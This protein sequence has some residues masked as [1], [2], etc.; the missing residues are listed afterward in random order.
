MTQQPDPVKGI[1][2]YLHHEGAKG[3][4]ELE[5]LMVRTG[6]DWTACLR[7][8]SEEQAAFQPEPS[9]HIQTPIS[10]KGPRWCVKEVVGHYLLSE[11][12]LNETVAGLAGVSPPRNPGPIVRGMGAQ[13][14]EYEALPLAA[15]REELSAFFEETVTLIGA[16]R[17][18]E[19]LSATFPHPALGPLNLKEWLVFHRGH[20]MDHIQQIERIK[21]NAGYP[22]A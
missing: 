1:V 3:F 10:G 17:S 9:E 22:T 8:V 2:N 16:L 14:T 21:A 11:R 5:A 7:E 4:E 20:A 19:N 6:N 13:S 18:S 12:S 15:L